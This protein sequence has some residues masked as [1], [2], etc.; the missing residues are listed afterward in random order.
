[1]PRTSPLILSF[2]L[3]STMGGRLWDCRFNKDSPPG[4]RGS[5]KGRSY[6]P[7]TS[8]VDWALLD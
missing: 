2:P 7:E 6:I 5:I 4:G 1:V 8:L 3:S